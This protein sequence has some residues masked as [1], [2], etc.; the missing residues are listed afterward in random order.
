MAGISEHELMS[1]ERLWGLNV[2]TKM[3]EIAQLDSRD[4]VLAFGSD[5][6]VL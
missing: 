4:K 3:E 2:D 5:V 1:D 6:D